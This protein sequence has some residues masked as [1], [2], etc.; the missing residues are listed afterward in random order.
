ML[1]MAKE[2]VF[3]DNLKRNLEDQFFHKQDQVLI[4]NLKKMR[5]LK[6]TREEL[7]KIS[8]IHDEAILQ[9]LVELNIR[10][11][12]LASL[13]L[14]PLI[15]VAWADGS[16]DESEKR[17]VLTAAE[18]MGFTKESTDYTLLKE[19]MQHKPSPRMLDAWIHY[20][21]GLC[22]QLSDEQRVELKK[23][24]V[25]NTRAVA[26]A[27]GGFMGLVNRISDAEKKVLAK[28]EGA[29]GDR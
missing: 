21:E 28:L 8:G 12:T 18:K 22:K 1:T 9:K 3:Q 6:E 17:A 2:D 27:S 10:P 24:L 15:E 20:I 23:N 26:E 14:V 5:Q 25:D 7:A 11:E 16:V 29:F 4:D 13:S 19:W